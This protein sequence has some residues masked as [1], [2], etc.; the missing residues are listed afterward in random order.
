MISRS[1]LVAAL[2]LPFASASAEDNTPSANARQMLKARLEQEAEHPSPK[3][4]P[5]ASNSAPSAN[6]ATPAGE[7]SPIL[8]AAPAPA[9]A[10]PAAPTKLDPQKEPATVLPKLQVNK[11]RITKL[12]QELAKQDQE[13]AREKKNTKPTD[14]DKALNDSKIAKPLAMFGGEST[15]FRQQVASERV[16]LMEDEKDIIE[17]IAHAKTKDEKAQLQKQLDALRAE[18]RELEKAMR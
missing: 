6:A 9:D 18:R 8:L 5:P 7:K 15:Q 16:S 12:D 3:P 13:I 10:P 11:G 17:A 14:L 4:A 2:L 1:V